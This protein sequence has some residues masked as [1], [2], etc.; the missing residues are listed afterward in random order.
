MD[1]YLMMVGDNVLKLYHVHL[2]YAD[3]L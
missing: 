2:R 3:E 1:I